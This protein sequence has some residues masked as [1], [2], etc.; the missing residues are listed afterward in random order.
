MSPGGRS[1]KR[2]GSR[3]KR[4]GKIGILAGAKM[5]R[6]QRTGIVI[7]RVAF[8]VNFDVPEL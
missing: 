7:A 8:I 5:K 3:R 2:N 6:K 1:G 4:Q